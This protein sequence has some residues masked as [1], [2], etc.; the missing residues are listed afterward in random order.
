MPMNIK[1]IL[2]ENLLTSDE[3]DWLCKFLTGKGS[4]DEIIMKIV[5]ITTKLQKMKR[6]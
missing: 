1:E 4:N 3:I 2:M 5:T 6:K